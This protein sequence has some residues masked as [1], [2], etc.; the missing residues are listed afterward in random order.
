M[1]LSFATILGG[2]CTLI[3]TST[4]VIVSGLVARETGQPLQLFDPVWVGLPCAL[5]GLTY[6]L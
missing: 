4:N 2:L 3:G 6:M 5:V 1:P